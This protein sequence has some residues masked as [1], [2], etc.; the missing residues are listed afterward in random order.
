MGMVYVNEPS[1]VVAESSNGTLVPLSWVQVKASNANFTQSVPTLDGQYS[2]VGA[3]FLPAGTYTV[4]FT[5]AYYK[6][7]NTTITL[8]WAEARSLLPPDCDNE[9]STTC[10]PPPSPPLTLS[11]AFAF[12]LVPV[13]CPCISIPDRL[14]SYR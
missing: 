14:R 11:Q 9:L 2:R 8:Q 12:V 5:V 7:Q 13:A 1:F 6:S 4:S 10:D 3:L